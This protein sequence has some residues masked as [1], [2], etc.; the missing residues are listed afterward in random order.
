MAER[1]RLRAPKE[2]EFTVKAWQLIT[3]EPTSPTYRK[4]RLGSSLLKQSS[5]LLTDRFNLMLPYLLSTRF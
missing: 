2:F 5:Y 3:H 4:A 1:W